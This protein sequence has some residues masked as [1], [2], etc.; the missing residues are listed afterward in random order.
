MRT[1][2]VDI[3]ID[4]ATAVSST[5]RNEILSPVYMSLLKDESVAVSAFYVTLN[6]IRQ[7]IVKIC[8]HFFF[9]ICQCLYIIKCLSNFKEKYFAHYVIKWENWMTDFASIK[10]NPF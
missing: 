5:T 4:L 9:I 1:K 10:R 7:Y 6:C 3:A 2:C 8:T